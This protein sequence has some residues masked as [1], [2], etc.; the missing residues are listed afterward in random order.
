[1]ARFRRLERFRAGD[2]AEAA[3]HAAPN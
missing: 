2:Q 3:G 1:L